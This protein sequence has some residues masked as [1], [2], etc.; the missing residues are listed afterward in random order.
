MNTKNNEHTVK[1]AAIAVAVVP[2]VSTKPA[3]LSYSSIATAPPLPKTAMAT[4]PPPTEIRPPSSRKTA[5]PAPVLIDPTVQRKPTPVVF[6]PATTV[7]PTAATVV[8]A[9]VAAV[10]TT[11]APVEVVNEKQPTPVVVGEKRYERE[12]LLSLRQKKL[13]LIV[14]E[15]LKDLEI[16]ATNQQKMQMQQH[17][18]D[19]SGGCNLPHH[20]QSGKDSYGAN[21]NSGSID[22]RNYQQQPGQVEINLYSKD[23]QLNPYVINNKMFESTSMDNEAYKHR[24]SSSGYNA[25]PATASKPY[26]QADTLIEVFLSFF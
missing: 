26:A 3:V 7:N 18:S 10:T 1:A 20:M 25:Q 23:T 14:P 6:T 9:P 17:M 21:N 12:F 24:T 5:A 4:Q 11:P 8:A 16:L 13:S 15:V 19:M 2:P 22:S